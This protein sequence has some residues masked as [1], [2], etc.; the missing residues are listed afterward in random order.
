LQID[1]QDGVPI[2]TADNYSG[3]ESWVT[4]TLPQDFIL[5]NSQSSLSG[6]RCPCDR[7]TQ[8]SVLGY[9][10]PSLPGLSPMHNEAAE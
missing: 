4:P 3:R 8:D 7:K 1:E 5:D 10:Q 9:F 2:G 6:L